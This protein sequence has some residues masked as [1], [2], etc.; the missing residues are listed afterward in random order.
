ML[1]AS[2]LRRIEVGQYVII[3][4]GLRIGMLA[5]VIEVAP[6]QRN[7]AT[8]YEYTVAITTEFGRKVVWDY[9]ATHE[10]HAVDPS[11]EIQN[12]S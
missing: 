4:V 5:K 12:H 8:Y 1:A 7:G 9:Y 10:L 6:L 3:H 11:F 2:R